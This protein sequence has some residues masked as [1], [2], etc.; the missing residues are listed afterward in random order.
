MEQLQNGSGSVR[1]GLLGDKALSLTKGL[2]HLREQVVRQGSGF[3][4]AGKA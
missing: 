4:W 1:R 2:P 3:C